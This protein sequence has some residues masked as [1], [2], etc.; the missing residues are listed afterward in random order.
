MVNKLSKRELEVL[1]L[2]SQGQ[3][4][5]DIAQALGI[6][7]FTVQNHVCRIL[8]KLRVNNRAAAARKYWEDSSNQTKK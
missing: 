8:L 5:A 6:S 4:N 7:I 1:E 3:R 2:I